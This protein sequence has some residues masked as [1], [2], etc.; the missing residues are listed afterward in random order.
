MEG[1]TEVHENRENKRSVK[2]KPA[3][4]TIKREKEGK[5]SKLRKTENETKEK[6]KRQHTQRDR[7]RR[8]GPA[9]TC[10]R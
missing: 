1:E 9:T 3:F 4:Q 2:K 8:I 7:P 5:K 10:G 6:P